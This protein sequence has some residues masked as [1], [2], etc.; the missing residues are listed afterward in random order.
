MADNDSDPEI[1]ISTS[2]DMTRD[3]MIMEASRGITDEHSDSSS[4][5]LSANDTT[6]FL[7]VFPNQPLYH[8]IKTS[9]SIVTLTLKSLM[10]YLLF[11]IIKLVN[12]LKGH[13]KA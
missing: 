5:L 3:G 11:Q 13:P 2:G 1:S 7:Y 6:L 10:S 12:V 9:L 4:S 8:V